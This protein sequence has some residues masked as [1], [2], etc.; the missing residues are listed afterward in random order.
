MTMKRRLVQL[1][2]AA[3]ITIVLCVPAESAATFFGEDPSAGGGLPIPNSAAAQAAFLSQLVSPKVEDFESIPVGTQFPFNV[4]FGA[5]TA[6]LS[7]TNNVSNTGVQNSNIAGRFPVSGS[8]YL[9]VGSLDAKSFTLTF[10]SPQ[11]A[12]GF[13]ATDAGDFN[14]QLTISLD[15][16][17]PVVIPHTVGAP[18]GA[19]LFF[20]IIDAANPFATVSFSN[21]NPTL[22]DA[23]GYDD[24]TIGRREQLVV[25]EP[26]TLAIWSLLATLGICVGWCRKRRG[27]T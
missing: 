8:Q 24:F 25:P 4:A 5:D 1:V 22:A 12:F 10:S 21:T 19:A 16:G 14:G 23:F 18:N 17:T 2:L 11:A 15:G 13:Y 9:N 3:G 7:G 27:Q 20:G 26:S 6:T